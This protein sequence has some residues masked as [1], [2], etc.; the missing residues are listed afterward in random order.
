M[1]YAESDL[2]V[3]ALFAI[4]QHS[5]GLATE[6]LIPILTEVMHPEGKDATL[7][8]GRKDTHFSQKVRNLKSH[9][10]LERKGLAEYRDGLFYITPRGRE[11]LAG[12]Q[13]EIAEALRTQGASPTDRDNEF[14]NDYKG[15][16]VE[17]G[18]ISYRNAKTRERSRQLTNIAMK[19]FRKNGVIPCIVCT[20]DFLNFYGERGRDY[21][22]I[23]HTH[24]IHEHEI[25]GEQH[26]VETVLQTLAPLCSNCHR[27]VH[28][29]RDQ[30]L[31][32]QELKA[33]IVHA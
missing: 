13:P 25:N 8:A 2:V 19:H 4:A 24:P 3:P 15:L 1:E 26:A 7:L 17:E 29:K 28:R 27:M 14:K 31:S 23:H 12:D 16:I 10:T 32:V 21:I 30:I 18:L 5:A 6:A 22:E 20:F 33:L 11:Y 9:D